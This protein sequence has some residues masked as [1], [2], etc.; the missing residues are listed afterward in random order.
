[1]GNELVVLES[2]TLV[3][4]QIASLGEE[5]VTR[6]IEF[7]TANIRNRNTRAAYARAVSNILGVPPALPGRQ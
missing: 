2:Q 1:M 3:P 4:V 5:A 7:F 6:F